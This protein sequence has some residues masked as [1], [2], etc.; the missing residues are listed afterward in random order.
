MTPLYTNWYF[1]C[2]TQTASW[3]E[4]R[5]LITAQ[6]ERR[7]DQWQR[8]ET[9]ALVRAYLVCLDELNVLR[10]IFAK[11]LDFVQRLRKDCENMPQL[12]GDVPG[13]P[14][15]NAAGETALDRIAFVEHQMKESREQCERL[16]ADLKESLNSVCPTHHSGVASSASRDRGP[17]VS[18]DTHIYKV[19][20]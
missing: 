9:I 5:L 3:K 6:K 2:P 13:N 11:K 17:I 20:I 19:T 4:N 1:L 12:Q 7:Y 16:A 10:E 15:D 14:P 18:H 8:N